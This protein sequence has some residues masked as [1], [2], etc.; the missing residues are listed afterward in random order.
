MSVIPVFLHY[1]ERIERLSHNVGRNYL[2][3]TFN[4][5]GTSVSLVKRDSK[6]PLRQV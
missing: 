6:C 2:K 4:G 5:L 3:D 1:L